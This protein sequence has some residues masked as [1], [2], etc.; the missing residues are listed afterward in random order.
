M[1]A[2]KHMKDYDPKILKKVLNE[3]GGV[4]IGLK[5]IYT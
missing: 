4:K 5:K 2:Y 3:E 1:G